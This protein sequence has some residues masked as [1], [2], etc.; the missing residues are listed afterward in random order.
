MDKPYFAEYSKGTLYLG[1]LGRD[2]GDSLRAAKSH[3]EGELKKEVSIG[4][5]G[6]SVFSDREPQRRLLTEDQVTPEVWNKLVEGKRVSC[7]KDRLFED[8]LHMDGNVFGVFHAGEEY[9]IET[10]SG[11]FSDEKDK[12]IGFGEMLKIKPVVG[13]LG[14]SF[15]LEKI[16]QRLGNKQEIATAA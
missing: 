8:Y 4:F 15:A 11:P 6:I 14:S 2:L 10:W 5:R 7:S 3:L 9:Q 13:S 1:F 12:I 16:A